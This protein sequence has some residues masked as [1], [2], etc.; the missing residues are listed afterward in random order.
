MM[1]V[2]G[3]HSRRRIGAEDVLVQVFPQNEGRKSTKPAL[4]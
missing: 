1:R 4:D 2:I 3:S